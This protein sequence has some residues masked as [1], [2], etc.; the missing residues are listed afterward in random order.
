M[1]QFCTGLV[2][3]DSSTE[4]EL[5]FQNIL[6]CQISTYM[7]CGYLMP[8]ICHHMPTTCLPYPHHMSTI[9]PPYAY[10][11]PTIFLPP[12]NLLDIILIPPHAYHKLTICFCLL[13]F[14]PL[15]VPRYEISESFHF[16][17]RCVIL[18]QK[19]HTLA[20]DLKVLP[21]L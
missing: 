14:P 12:D 4:L 13:F 9:C 6:K 1:D 19:I 5:Y 16:C 11:M 2:L 3:M 8:T 10:H 18:W 15:H 21:L 7:S 20:K 17:S